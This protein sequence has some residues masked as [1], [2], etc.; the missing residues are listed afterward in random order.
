V[1]REQSKAGFDRFIREY[2]DF[3]VAVPGNLYG[4]ARRLSL[5]DWRTYCDT[6]KVSGLAVKVVKKAPYPLKEVEGLIEVDERLILTSTA[7]RFFSAKLDIRLNQELSGE[8][9]Y[10]IDCTWGRRGLPARIEFE[11]TLMLLYESRD[12]KGALT[13]MDGPLAS[14][15]PTEDDNIFTLSTVP[16]TP[17]HDITIDV[18][19]KRAKMEKKI[20]HYL[21]AFPDLFRYVGVQSSRKTKLLDLSANRACTVY[22]EKNEFKVMSG[23]IDAIFV[24]GDEIKCALG[25]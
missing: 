25:L 5:V 11:Q 6:M 2:P 20:R 18:Q 24:A 16:H 23:K 4:I 22:R 9:D 12:W 21:P 17:C 7:A 19:E 1:T 13:L 3:S 8:F 14:I 10:T 15:Y